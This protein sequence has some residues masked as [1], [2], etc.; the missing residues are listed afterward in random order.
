MKQI[1]LIALLLFTNACSQADNCEE[2][3]NERIQ[4]F[5]SSC[6]IP[7]VYTMEDATIVIYD[8]TYIE[9]HSEYIILN[10]NKYLKQ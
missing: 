10:E 2:L 3:F 5:Y 7:I 1:L 8:S 9:I 6:K 4:E